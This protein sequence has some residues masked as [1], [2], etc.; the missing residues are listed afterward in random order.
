MGWNF[1]NLCVDTIRR[2][3]S[4][5]LNLT[6]KGADKGEKTVIMDTADYTEYCGIL[7]N[8]REFWEELD[9]NPTVIYT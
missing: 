3:L 6:I 2:Y 8:D 9:A 1:K 5:N 4:E 7:L